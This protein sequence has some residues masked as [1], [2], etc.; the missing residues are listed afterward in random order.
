MLLVGWCSFFPWQPWMALY[1]VCLLHQDYSMLLVWLLP[2][3]HGFHPSY[4]ITQHCLLTHNIMHQLC[5]Q[6]YIQCH[7]CQVAFHYPGPKQWE[8]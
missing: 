4:L 1:Q 5:H 2:R 3:Q 7:R 6:G 8:A